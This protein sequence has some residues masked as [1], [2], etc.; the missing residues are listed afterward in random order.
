M[1]THASR[2]EKTSTPGLRARAPAK[3]A[4]APSSLAELQPLLGNRALQS[5]LSVET[6]APC[7]CGGSCAHCSGELEE[8]ARHALTEPSALLSEEDLAGLVGTPGAAV[9]VQAPPAGAGGSVCCRGGA[10]E[11]WINPS[12][13]AWAQPCERRHEEKHVADF[14]ADPNYRNWCQ[15]KPD[16]DCVTY[17]NNDDARRFETA[18]SDVEIACLDAAIPG[19]AAADQPGMRNRRD[20]TLPNYKRSFASRGC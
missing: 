8:R 6:A 3:R 5:L 13:P 16:G 1:L 9:P 4:L 7:A 18:A 11:V 14:Q 20:V 10:M 12:E 19:A 15:G 17:A 2:A